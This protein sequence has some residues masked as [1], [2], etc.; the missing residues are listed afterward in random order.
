MNN[1]FKMCVLVYSFI[2]AFTTLSF[3]Q[4]INPIEGRWDMVISQEGKDLPSWLEIRHSGSRTLVGRFVYAMGS[5]RPISEV[6]MVDGKFSFAIPPQWEDGN[7]YME[8]EGSMSGDVLKGTMLYTNGKTYNWVATRAPKLE[9]TKN[10]KWG[11]PI[12]LFNG[13]DLSGWQAMGENQ[14]IVESGVLKSPKSGSNLVSE[15]KFDDFKLHLEF[16][17]PK[18]SNSGVYLR[19]RYEVQI[20]DSKGAEPSDVEYSGVYGFLTPNEVVAKAA[21]EWQ[22]YDITLI[23]R[24]VTIVAN[25]AQVICD[26]IIPGITGGALDSKEGEPGPLYFQGDHGPIEFRNIIITPR[27]D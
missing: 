16:K 26:Q 2:M 23:G 27:I 8:F 21:G 24:R 1:K 20:T 18:G 7:T 14:W 25:G 5:A 3:A 9:Y 17:Y 22:E 11:K 13:K 12:K 4:Q 15:Q 6:K 19:G 10:A